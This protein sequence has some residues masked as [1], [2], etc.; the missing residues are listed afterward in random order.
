[1]CLRL[2]Y[3]CLYS[4]PMTEIV[5]SDI[6]SSSDRLDMT[7]SISLLITKIIEPFRFLSDKGTIDTGREITVKTHETVATISYSDQIMSFIISIMHEGVNYNISVFVAFMNKMPT[8]RDTDVCI[9][10]KPLCPKITPFTGFVE[11]YIYYPE[12]VLTP[13]C[14]RKTAEKMIQILENIWTSV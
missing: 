6:L 4:I 2:I 13:S 8:R 7:S 9:F 14:S 10:G 5:D 3:I 11:V 1:M 12:K